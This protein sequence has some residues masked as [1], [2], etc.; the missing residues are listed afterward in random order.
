MIE[1]TF[2]KIIL[3]APDEELEV[4]AKECLAC[5][6]CGVWDENSKLY[7]LLCEYAYWNNGNFVPAM[8]IIIAVALEFMK[9][10]V[11]E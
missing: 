11:K 6:S 5:S 3:N 2:M 1:S 4:Y 8:N 7:S 10:N 9:R